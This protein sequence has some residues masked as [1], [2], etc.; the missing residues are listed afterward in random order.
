MT[1][2]DCLLDA[3]RKIDAP[4]HKIVDVTRSKADPPFEISLQ[5]LLHKLN[6]T[7]FYMYKLVSFR[8]LQ[9]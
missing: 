4:F 5:N 6:E 1:K 3:T 7:I 9:Q 2:Y 8:G